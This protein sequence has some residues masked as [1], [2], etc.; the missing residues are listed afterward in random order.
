MATGSRSAPTV[1]DLAI[2]PAHD[3]DLYYK[4]GIFLFEH[5]LEPNPANYGFAHAY[6]SGDPAIGAA[7]DDATAGQLRLTQKIVDE[8]VG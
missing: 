5:R 4:V 6:V 8:I 7:V 1:V 2:A 3:R